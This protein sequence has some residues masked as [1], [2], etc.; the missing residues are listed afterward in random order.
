MDKLQKQIAIIK[1]QKDDLD[2]KLEQLLE[3]RN[4]ALV[5]MIKSISSPDL[6]IFTLIGGILDVIEK[7]KH[8][9]NLVEEWHSAGEKFCRKYISKSQKV[10]ADS[11]QNHPHKN[12][13]Q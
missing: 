12:D 13:V 1:K 7:S 3:Q 6:D 5:E 2:V 8:S 4:S 11:K 10:I 9:S